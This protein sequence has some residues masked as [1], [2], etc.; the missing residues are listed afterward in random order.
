MQRSQDEIMQRI[1]E[2]QKRDM[3]G[4]EWME[5]VDYLNFE[6]AQEVAPKITKA[7]Y[8]A[9]VVER[10]ERGGLKRKMKDYV[11]FAWEKANGC[12]GISAQRS[13]MHFA[14]WFWLAG[15]DEF[16]NAIM[17]YMAHDEYQFYGKPMLE[18]ISDKL[19][20]DWKKLDD[21]RRVNTD[22]E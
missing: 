20:V 11:P 4:F 12:R 15:D 8:D 9:M 10:K 18:R 3:L 7:D 6:N 1:A 2:A 13:L 14:A 22:E 16:S 21:G 17:D 19:G 5:Y